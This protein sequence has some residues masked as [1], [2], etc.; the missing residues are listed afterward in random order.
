MPTMP[1]RQRR[2]YFWLAEIILIFA[3]IYGLLASRTWVQR[4]FPITAA[5]CAIALAVLY[6]AHRNEP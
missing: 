4:S 6:H 2:V 3:F 1:R 5:V